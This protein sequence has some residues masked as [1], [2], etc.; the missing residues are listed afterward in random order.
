[1]TSVDNGYLTGSVRISPFSPVI[2]SRGDTLGCALPFGRKYPPSII[3]FASD[4]CSYR[5]LPM[6]NCDPLCAV[7]TM[8]C[9]PGM[10]SV[11]AALKY[12]I[13]VHCLPTVTPLYAAVNPSGVG[14]PDFVRMPMSGIGSR[15]PAAFLN[16]RSPIPLYPVPC[17]TV[18]VIGLV[19][20]PIPLNTPYVIAIVVAVCIGS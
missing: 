7:N 14:T 5:R 18:G 11:F 8:P 3:P 13:G 19:I 6:R 9:V 15:V 16:P 4:T 20:A 2:S 12:S 17:K 1:M 10:T